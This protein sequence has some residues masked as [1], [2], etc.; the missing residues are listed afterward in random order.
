MKNLKSLSV[1]FD[2]KAVKDDGSF[3]GYASTFGNVDQGYDVVMPGAFDKSL[4]LRPAPQVKM[5]WQ[6]D[7]TKPIGVW[8]DLSPD[9]RGLYAKGKILTNLQQGAECYQMM[10]AGII[11]SMSIGYRTMEADYTQNGVRQLKELGLYE[12][13]MVTFPMNEQATVTALKEINP[14][15][16]EAVLR[17]AGLSRSDAVKAVAVFKKRLCE[18]GE[19]VETGA[20]DADLS[21]IELAAANDFAHRMEQLFKAS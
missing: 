10:K 7:A 6:H 16:L 4:L 12:V 17:D 18:T 21:A 15:E 20:R 9:D 19:T 11:D 14:R 1:A 2:A 5:L 3:E 8:S 13:S